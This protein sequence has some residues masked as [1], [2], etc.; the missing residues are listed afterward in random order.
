MAKNGST[1]LLKMTIIFAKNEHKNN[2]KKRLQ[3]R[4]YPARRYKDDGFCTCILF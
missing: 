1:F 4:N 3:P 2:V